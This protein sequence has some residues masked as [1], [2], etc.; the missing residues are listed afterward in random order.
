AA[1]RNS[2]NVVRIKHTSNAKARLEVAH[3]IMGITDHFGR[4]MESILNHW[5]KVPISYEAV[6]RLI[7]LAMVP[8]TEVRS[9]LQQGKDEELAS[10]FKNTCE[11]VFEHGMAA[12]SAQLATTK[13]TLFG[14]YNAV[15][16]YFQNVRSYKN[17]EAK[18]KSILMG[19]TAQLRSQKA[20]D[21][22][23]GFA[24]HGEQILKLN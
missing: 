23:A 11:K 3:R 5:T 19:G 6:K 8:N 21:L 20:F 18:V 17:E 16:G 4:Q 22:C 14:A 9:H 13:G 15:T 10:M 24:Q 7:Q 12:D 2:S 1:M